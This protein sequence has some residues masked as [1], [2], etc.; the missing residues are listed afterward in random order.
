MN[1]KVLVLGDGLLG[2]ELVKQTD[3]DF[4]S[5]KWGNFD[6]NNLHLIS[7]GYN[8]I[9][10]CIAH[11]DSYSKERDTHMDVNVRFVRDLIKYCNKHNIKLIHISSDF[12][13]ANNN[14]FAK[15]EDIPRC[16]N[17]WYAY[18]K[19]L[20][21]ELIMLNSNDYLICRC[22]HKAKPFPYEKAWG[23]YYTNADYVDVISELIIKLINKGAIGIINVGTKAKTMLN[24]AKE[25]KPN[26]LGTL[27]PPYVPE[28]VTMDLNKLEKWI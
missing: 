27:R 15:E 26:I 20:A 17:S 22:S 14:F 4:V 12:V 28:N 19:V 24:L 23:N 18:S 2:S 5:R 9:V 6:I 10:N 16:D 11:T 21:D 3:W 13:Y 1:Y 25:T 8:V 7:K